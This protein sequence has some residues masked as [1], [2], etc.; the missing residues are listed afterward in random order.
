MPATDKSWNLVANHGDKTLMRNTVG[1]KISSLFD[2][3]YTPACKS[4]D[5]MVNGEFKGNYILCDKVQEGEG[6]IEVTKMNKKC[7]KEP[8][9]TGGY[10]ILADFWAKED[11]KTYYESKKGVIYTIN[12]PEEDNIIPEQVEYIKNAFNLAEEES[13]NNIINKIDIESFCKYLLIE[14]LCGNVE[15]FFSTY[16][17]KERNDDKIYFGP[18]WDFDIAFDNYNKTFPV[19]ERK[20][21]TIKIGKSAG[22]M[23]NLALKILSNENVLKELKNIWNKYKTIASLEVLNKFIDEESKYIDQSQKLNFMRWDILNTL[24]LR[25]PVARGSFKAEVDFLKEFLQ[26]K[27]ANTD[28]Y[29]NNANS[30]NI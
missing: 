18:V 25:N 2:M 13:Y 19:Y 3:K 5:V 29:V 8:E 1:L 30:S 12:Y 4:V 21:F 11:N 7:T 20:D 28:E 23:N 22:T 14:D 17:T 16:M 9:I 24:I 15:A 10:V 6:R 27:F 26:K